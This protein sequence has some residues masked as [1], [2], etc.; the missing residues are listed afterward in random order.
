MRWILH[1]AKN[2]A[3]AVLDDD[4]QFCA[5]LKSDGDAAAQGAQ[6]GF[7]IECGEDR[8]SQVNFL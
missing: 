5:F 6:S 3:N 7:S 4:V 1:N 8:R 2:F